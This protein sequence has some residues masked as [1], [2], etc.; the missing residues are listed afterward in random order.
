MLKN[1]RSGAPSKLL[2]GF[3]FSSGLILRLRI[4][5]VIS[6]LVL[7]TRVVIGFAVR[8]EPRHSRESDALK[9]GDAE[10]SRRTM[11]AQSRAATAKRCFQRFGLCWPSGLECSNF[12]RISALKNS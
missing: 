8:P 9:K 11:S 10:A 4:V 12:C 7:E 2:N 6:G 3:C 5:G 1:L